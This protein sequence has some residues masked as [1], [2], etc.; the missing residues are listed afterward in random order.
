MDTVHRAVVLTLLMGVALALS[1]TLLVPASGAALSAGQGFSMLIRSDGSLVSWGLNTYGETGT[2]RASDWPQRVGTAKDWETACCGYRHTLAVKADGSLWAWGYNSNGQ[3]GMATGSLRTP[4]RVGTSN[5]WAQVS[6]GGMFSLAL[7]TDGSLWAW[8][9]NAKGQLGLGAGDPGDK[10]APTRVGA[11]TDW[12]VVSAGYDHVLALKTD[13]SLWAWGANQYGELGQGTAGDTAA[14]PVPTMVGTDTDWSVVVAGD[15]ASYALKA[16]GALWSWGNNAVGQLGLGDTAHRTLPIS[17][18]PSAHWT[19]IAAPRYADVYGSWSEAHA[20]ALRSDGTIWSCG[21]NEAGQLGIPRISSSSLFQQVGKATTW[22]SLA[23]G[24][25]T[26]FAVDSRGTVWAWGI[27]S[28]GQLGQGMSYIPRNAPAT[29]GMSV[30]DLAGPS[31]WCGGAVAVYRGAKATL[32]YRANDAVSKKAE[33]SL[34]I[35]TLKGK[36]AKVVAPKPSATGKILRYT[37]VCKLKKGVYRYSVYAV[38][39]SGNP[40]RNVARGRLTVL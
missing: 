6:A 18:D 5:D 35:R 9:A 37:F 28:E 27:D 15:G 4:T 16:S 25:E 36:Q 32:K 8:G 22:R 10:A 17:V 11:A 19:A 21:D 40:Q 31:T 13:G 30:N 3:L 14:L 29:Y 39:A 34:V 12:R 33:I 2:G 26:S 7:K 38:D 1:A 24:D 23:A 20:I